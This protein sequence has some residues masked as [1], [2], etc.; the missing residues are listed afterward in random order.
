MIVSDILM[1]SRGD[2]GDAAVSRVAEP[3]FTYQMPR[4][5]HAEDSGQLF[6][7]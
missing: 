4:L 3:Q 2:G 1:K 7:F 6:S 5:N